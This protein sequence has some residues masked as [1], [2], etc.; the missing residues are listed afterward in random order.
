MPEAETGEEL[1]FDGAEFQSDEMKGIR[2]ECW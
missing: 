1:L 2:D